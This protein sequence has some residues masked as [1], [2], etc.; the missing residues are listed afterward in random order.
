M[1]TF[2]SITSSIDTATSGRKG[3]GRWKPILEVHEHGIL[4]ECGRIGRD[5]RNDHHVS[6]VLDENTRVP[7]IRMIVVR[8][9]R[10]HEV[11]LPEPDL[12]NDF[13]AWLE[14][15]QQLA[16]VIVQHDVIDA[17]PAAGF[18]R[19]RAATRGERATALGLMPGIAIRDRDEAN[20]VPE[21]RAASL[22]C[23]QPSDRNRPGAPRTR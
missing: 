21:G 14:R 2:L 1:S 23:R 11:R 5:V 4:A 3:F 12:P 13:F 22:P 18:L 17:D 20:A 6:R 15:R 10:Q 7:V 16:V 8:S 19:F 9:R